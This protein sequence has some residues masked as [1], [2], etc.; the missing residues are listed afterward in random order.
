MKYSVVSVAIALALSKVAS[1][2]PLWGQCGGI[3]YSGSTVCD[4]GVC[5]KQN[6]YYYQ[7]IPGTNPTPTTQPGGGTTTTST[8]PP[9]GT[10][11]ICPGNLTKFRFFGVNQAGAEFGGDVLPG[12]LGTHYT[13]PSPSSIDYF[14][15]QGFNSFRIPFSLERM[16]PNTNGGLTGSFDRTYL[17]GLK[18]IVN[19]VTNKGSYAIIEPH[20]YMRY[21]GNVITSTND[22]KTWWRNMANEFKNNN[23]V[24]F[25]GL[26][27]SHDLL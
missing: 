2:V 19:Y 20:N 8:A 25:G 17:S 10:N 18:T 13:W 23:R 14:V 27:P 21:Y 5:V 4:S 9:Q 15:G 22:F 12:V 11:R 3:G 6:D 7:C 16:S 26:A 24:I 1:A